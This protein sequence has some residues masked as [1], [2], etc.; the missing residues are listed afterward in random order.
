MKEVPMAALRGESYVA[1]LHCEYRDHIREQREL[2]GAIVRFAF[3]SERDDWVQTLVAAGQGFCLLPEYFPRLPGVLARPLV[4]PEIVREVSLVTM[5][6]R[7]FS[8]AVATFVRA[9]KAHKWPGADG[10]EQVA[11]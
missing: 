1:R 10:P 2:H 4:E 7:R 6:G 9:I 3:R 5:A 8:P 11:A